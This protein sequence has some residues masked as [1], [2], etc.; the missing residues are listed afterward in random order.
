MTNIQNNGRRSSRKKMMKKIDENLFRCFTLTR[1]IWDVVLIGE[2]LVPKF[3]IRCFVGRSERKFERFSSISTQ[4]V[5]PWVFL[6]S[7]CKSN[8]LSV[9]ISFFDVSNRSNGDRL[10]S[11][12]DE[13]MSDEK[14]RSKSVKTF[15]D[16]VVARFDVCF[17]SRRIRNVF[18][19]SFWLFNFITMS[20]DF[21]KR[22]TKIRWST[23]INKEN[24]LWAK[25]ELRSDWLDLDYDDQVLDQIYN[26]FLPLISN[27]CPLKTQ[28]ELKSFSNEFNLL[29]YV[30]P[31][32]QI[33][34][35]SKLDEILKSLELLHQDFHRLTT[36][37]MSKNRW[38]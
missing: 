5:S 11:V 10:E 1:W 35:D 31:I 34:Q 21:P 38:S 9:T 19:K 27:R 13:R 25:L 7:V 8:E 24:D 12:W 22:K 6:T 33:H 20:R 4:V 16:S 3:S 17:R 14:T 37:L 15:C 32:D 36:K 2:F 28:D 18:G 26:P 23:K 30:V 29:E